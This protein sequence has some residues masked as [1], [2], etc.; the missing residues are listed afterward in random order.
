M[1]K[2]LGCLQSLDV[3]SAVD[4]SSADAG[5]RILRKGHCCLMN[6]IN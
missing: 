3:F 2:E 6:H 4:Y 5:C 1:R